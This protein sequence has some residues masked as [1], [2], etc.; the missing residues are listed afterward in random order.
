MLSE[1]PRLYMFQSS[2]KELFGFASDQSGGNL[3][4]KFGPWT[5]V[6]VVRPDQAPPHGL[7]RA[8][9]EDGIAEFGFQLWRRKPPAEKAAPA[10]PAAK[11]R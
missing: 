6:G 1:R 10:A 8:A 3:P 4:E 9:I 2:S 5:N 11:A 7:K